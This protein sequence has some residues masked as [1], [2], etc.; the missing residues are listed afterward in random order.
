MGKPH[1]MNLKTNHTALMN[2][3]METSGN[4][5]KK[6]N[7]CETRRIPKTFANS[8]A[9]DFASFSNKESLS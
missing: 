7:L 4:E 5:E 9:L 1:A 6:T 2:T 8:S 3:A